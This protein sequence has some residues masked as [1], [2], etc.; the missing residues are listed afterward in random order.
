[1]TI[2]ATELKTNL[3]KYLTLSIEEDVYISKNGKLVAK[4]SNPYEDRIAI[5]ESLHGI[6]ANSDVTLEEA[7]DER[8]KKYESID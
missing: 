3:S 4:L 1:M 6:L 7:R 2:S 8:I 5:A